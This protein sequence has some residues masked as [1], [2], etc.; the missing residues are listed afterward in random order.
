MQ[1]KQPRRW[2]RNLGYINVG[3]SIAKYC[4]QTRSHDKMKFRR[5]HDVNV[6]FDQTRR[7]SLSNPRTSSRDDRLSAGHIHELKEEPGTL[8]II[9]LTSLR[10]NVLHVLT[11]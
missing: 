11:T 10:H 6:R 8:E 3:V 7:L 4:G 9:N 2:W 1:S 5:G